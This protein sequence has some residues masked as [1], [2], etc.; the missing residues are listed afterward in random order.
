M[1]KKGTC[2]DSKDWKIRIP[3]KT[4]HLY[5]KIDFDIWSVTFSIVFI[6]LYNKSMICRLQSIKKQ[7][8][9]IIKWWNIFG[10]IKSN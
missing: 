8:C 1:G 10:F 9:D 7:R 2:S 4:L 5:I 6:A 3:T